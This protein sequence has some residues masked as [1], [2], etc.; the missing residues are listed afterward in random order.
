[1]AASVSPARNDRHALARIR[2][3]GQH[4]LPPGITLL[5]PRSVHDYCRWYLE[6]EH[7]KGRRFRRTADPAR[8]RAMMESYHAGKFSPVF[9]EWE[10]WL[11]RIETPAALAAL[12]IPRSAQSISDGLVDPVRLRTVGVAVDRL[13]AAQLFEGSDPT[14]SPKNPFRRYYQRFLRDGLQLRGDDRLVLRSLTRT[15]QRE[16]GQRN[17]LYLLD[18]VGR[19]LPYLTLVRQGRLRFR[20]IEVY[21]ALAPPRRYTWSATS[22]SHATG[23]ASPAGDG[24]RCVPGRHRRG[25]AVYGPYASLPAT[26]ITVTFHLS[27]DTGRRRVAN[28]DV[29][30]SRRRHSLASSQVN[31]GGRVTLRFQNHTT[32]PLEFRVYWHGRVPLEIHR[33]DVELHGS[34]SV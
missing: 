33:V 10:W 30:D 8:Q 29:Y 12:M 7:R 32:N 25:H 15:E 26:R 21:L 22:L 20:P 19:S 13:Q 18:G 34:T 4:C 6:R 16:M 2:D 11:A 9:A 27:T 5:A 31:E 3:L 17:A 28:V 24:W 23:E 14:G 1:M